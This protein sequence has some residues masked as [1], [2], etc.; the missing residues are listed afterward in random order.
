MTLN[1]T[2]VL[3]SLL[4]NGV[5]CL[6]QYFVQQWELKRGRIPARGSAIH[7][8][9]QKFNHWQD[10]HCQTWGDMVGLGLVVSGFAHL[11]WYGRIELGEWAIFLSLLVFGAWSWY[12]VGTHQKYKPNW[13]FP[14]P[15]K[16]SLGGK[17]HLAYFGVSVA[18]SSICLLHALSGN[19]EKTS[20]YLIVAGYLVFLSAVLVDVILG[21]KNPLASEAPPLVEFIKTGRIR[22]TIFTFLLTLS[23]FVMY[24]EDRVDWMVALFAALSCSLLHMSIMTFNDWYDRSHDLQKGKRLAYDHPEAFWSY[25]VRLTGITLAA[26]SLLATL[27]TV[28]ALFCFGTLVLGLAYSYLQKLVVV[29]N[30]IVAGCGASPVLCGSVFFQKSDAYIWTWYSVFFTLILGREIIKDIEDVNIDTG[31]KNTLPV[32][33]GTSPAKWIALSISSLSGFFIFLTNKAN[34][35]LAFLVVLVYKFVKWDPT[36]IP[37]PMIIFHDTLIGLLAICLVVP[38]KYG[39]DREAV[40][41]DMWSIEHFLWGVVVLASLKRFFPKLSVMKLLSITLAIAYGWELVEY[42]LELGVFGEGVSA[43]KVGHEHWS[44]RLIGDPLL[45]LLGGYVQVRWQ[46]AWK[47][48]VLPWMVWGI[49]NYLAP[50]SMF[51]TRI[52]LDAL[53]W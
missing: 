11:A 40:M 10:G 48:A 9:N 3:V 22:G 42:L 32:T 12:R 27:N 23:G 38:E 49:A 29:N 6:L 36:S 2:L 44:N 28:V 30:L 39:I 33:L 53:S 26:I 15:G 41:L 35:L 50:D 51:I 47:W 31:H 17:V 1:W 46:S 18:V 16:V 21:H 45:V 43:W 7:G 37:K 5:A 14:E 20:I 13:S 25:W 8:T 19:I 4:L 52:I 34:E 24:G